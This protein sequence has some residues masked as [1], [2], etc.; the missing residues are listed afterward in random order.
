MELDDDGS[1]AVMAHRLLQAATLVQ[2]N[3]EVLLEGCERI[4]PHDRQDLLANAKDRACELTA[5]L[6]HLVLGHG[7]TQQD[8][9]PTP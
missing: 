6:Q 8:A 9:I 3:I 4:T 5:G 7:P 1:Q 2:G